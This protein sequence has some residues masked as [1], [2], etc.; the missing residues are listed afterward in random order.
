MEIQGLEQV[1]R[2]NQD[3][4]INQSKE[5]DFVV[6]I[7]SN[8]SEEEPEREAQIQE[9]RFGL[10]Q[11]N[12]NEEGE[13]EEKG[14]P[15]KSDG[16]EPFV[17][18][19]P[20]EEHSFVNLYG[21]AY[22]Q[23]MELN[24]GA[25]ERAL[26]I[27]HLDGKVFLTTLTPSRDRSTEAQ[28]NELVAKRFLF[29]GEKT[30]KEEE[31][32][33]LYRV[34][35]VPEGWRIEVNDQRITEELTEKRL[36]GKELQKA[37]VGKFNGLVKEGLFECIRREKLSSEKDKDF[38]PKLLNSMAYLSIPHLERFLFSF[39]PIY[40]IPNYVIILMFLAQGNARARLTNQGW[41]FR[42]HIDS[43]W[44]YFMP[45]VEL[46][47]VARAFAY[48]VGKGRTLVREIKEDKK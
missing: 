14:S 18:Q 39:S 35:S 21:G 37:F 47:K 2:I 45:P 43:S 26:K 44:E 24:R 19:E 5:R 9:I 11:E 20:Q 7:E 23:R 16:F 3:A 1:K 33:P 4:G 6:P 10:Q 40:L 8:H 41:V 48:T 22:S 30:Q 17:S 36:D 46:D 15:Q 34:V 13:S 38:I 31:D 32:N 28:S 25:V 42:K 27:A 12:N 29:F